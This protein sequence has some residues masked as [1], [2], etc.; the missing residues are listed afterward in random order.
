MGLL[1]RRREIEIES[2]SIP[3]SAFC[4]PHSA[5]RIP[6][7]AFCIPHSSMARVLSA[8]V[9]IP[10]LLAALW[11]GAPIWFSAIAAVGVLLGLY[12]YYRLASRGG[13]I[14]GLLAAAAILAAFYFGRHDLIA[15]I[16]A[17]L[18]IV[19]ML[20]QL[21]TRANDEDFGEMLPVAATKVFGV[22]YVAVLGGYIIAIRVIESPIPQLPAKLLTLFFIVVF[23]GD[24]GAYYTGR[25]LGRRRLAPRVSPGKTV[26]GAIGGLA[27]NVI[28]ALIAHFWFFPELK[29]VY[30]IPL[31]LVMGALGITGDLCESMLK[32]GARAKDAGNLIPGHGGLLDRLDSMLFN[33]PLLYYFYWI[34]LK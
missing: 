3:H 18:V 12:E 29:I 7:S 9:F 14:Q 19:E 31:A 21:F 20:V 26:E 4:I 27:G 8:I 15:A 33:A 28:A 17:A 13:E 32:R 10:I 1:N 5:F 2:F 6:H 25:T 34:F 23:A 30:A 24:T 22:L 11:I 16:I